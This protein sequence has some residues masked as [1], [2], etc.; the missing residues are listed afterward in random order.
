MAS[1]SE[2]RL[3]PSAVMPDG[4]LETT[5]TNDSER[6]DKFLDSYRIVVPVGYCP[7][8]Y[9]AFA[10]RNGIASEND[11]QKIKR[12]LNT[13]LDNPSAERFKNVLCFGGLERFHRPPHGDPYVHGGLTDRDYYVASVLFFDKNKGR[14]Y[15]VNAHTSDKWPLNGCIVIQPGY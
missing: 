15:V 9:S 13:N 11:L 14:F 4:V 8:V 2:K 10:N 7:I 3:Q 12:R 1:F 6:R 5:F